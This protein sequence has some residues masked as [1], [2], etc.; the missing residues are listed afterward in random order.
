MREIKF[1]CWDG[2][3]MSS[4]DRN[5]DFSSNHEGRYA[6]MSIV[7]DYILMQ[8]TGLKDENG[9]EIYEGDLLKHTGQI[10]NTIHT[11]QFRGG[12]YYLGEGDASLLLCDELINNSKWGVIGNVF[13]HPDLIKEIKDEHGK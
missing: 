8:Y 5:Y 9:K 3:K 1:R 7:S 10:T 12:C 11:V 6:T 2:N 4:D 13:E